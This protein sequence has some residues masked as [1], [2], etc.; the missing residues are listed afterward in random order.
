MIEIKKETDYYELLK[1]ARS[2]TQDQ[3]KKSYY[4]LVQLYHPDKI[5]DPEEKKKSEDMIYILNEAYKT[6]K[7]TNKRKEYDKTLKPKENY[8]AAESDKVKAQKYY[9]GALVAVSQ[10]D[11]KKAYAFLVNAMKYNPQN[12]DIISLLGIVTVKV[13]KNLNEGVTL[14]QKAIDSDP[15]NIKY[16]YNM[17]KLYKEA[18]IYQK[19]A[20]FFKDALFWD[21]SFIEAKEALNDINLKLKSL[22]KKETNQSFL[23]KIA[24]FLTKKK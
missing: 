20:K 23:S 10:K 8:K 4:K 13:K 2:A 17:G 18:E 16:L 12:F 1:V 15:G 24:S 21:P 19:A 9:K 5:H 14:C 22:E 11:Y 7:D 6:L 3:I